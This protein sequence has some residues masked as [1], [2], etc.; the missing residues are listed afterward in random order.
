MWLKDINVLLVSLFV[1]LF[2]NVWL[3]AEP[4][5]VART[6]EELPGKLKE[7]SGSHETLY[8]SCWSLSD[9]S[10]KAAHGEN[11][12]EDTKS[13]NEGLLKDDAS[14]K[15]LDLGLKWSNFGNNPVW[16]NNPKGG[17]SRAGGPP[18]T[19][20]DCRVF[21]RLSIFVHSYSCS[22]VH[23]FD[24]L[25]LLLTFVCSVQCSSVS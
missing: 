7:R 13:L 4:E 18:L 15:P 6:T 8:H 23:P 2:R 11:G 3:K 14:G 16:E 12:K 21:T 24:R 17:V 1:R 22:I 19:A 9:F 10:E 25:L 20:F 5:P